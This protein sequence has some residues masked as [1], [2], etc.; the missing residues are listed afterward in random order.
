MGQHLR[1]STLRVLFVTYLP[2]VHIHELHKRVVHTTTVLDCS[3]FLSKY[4][5][6]R[7]A[8]GEKLG[9]EFIVQAGVLISSALEPVEKVSIASRQT[10]EGSEN[11]FRD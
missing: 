11:D 1:F 9:D 10:P 4:S 8:I 7:S 3:L 6:I 2:E 5:E